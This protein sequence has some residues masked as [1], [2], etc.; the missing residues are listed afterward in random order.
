MVG[1][2]NGEV[3]PLESVTAIDVKAP[4]MCLAIKHTDRYES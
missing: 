4:V 1:I 2:D 3:D